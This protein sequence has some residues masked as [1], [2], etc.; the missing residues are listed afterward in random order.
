MNGSGPIDGSHPAH[1]ITKLAESIEVPAHRRHA[2]SEP[3]AD[4][5]ALVPGRGIEK[6]HPRSY[7][8]LVFWGMAYLLLGAGITFL[9]AWLFLG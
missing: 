5:P 8:P 7:L 4:G 2:H 9:I 1:R 3:V 6:R